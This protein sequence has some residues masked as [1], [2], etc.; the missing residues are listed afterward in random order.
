MIVIELNDVLQVLEVSPEVWVGK[1]GLKGIGH[2]EA[3]ASHSEARDLHCLTEH[4]QHLHAC[5][6]HIRHPAECDRKVDQ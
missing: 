5:R 1:L 2:P 4:V 3:K 6:S